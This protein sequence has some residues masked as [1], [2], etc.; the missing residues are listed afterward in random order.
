MTISAR[1]I[2][3]D[4]SGHDVLQGIEFNFKPG[5]CIAILGTNGTGKSTLL[6]CLDRILKPSQGDFVINGKNIHKIKAIDAA[7][8]IG[9]VAQYNNKPLMTVFDTILLGRK[10]HIRWAATEND[11]RIVNE[12]VE[13]MDLQDYVYRNM[14]ELSGG[15]AQKVFIARALVQKPSVLLLDE[16]TSSLD[17]KNQIDTVKLMRHIARTQNITVFATMHDMNL[18]LR[19]ADKFLLLKEGSVYVSGGSEVLNSKNIF[20]VYGLDA[21][22]GNINGQQVIVPV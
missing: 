10:P 8:E 19:F 13:Q 11:L 7:K 9:Y 6:K 17:I 3:F 15:E 18:S 5:E 20:A 1:S 14:N 12:I 16:P 2:H 21:V 22:V 4:Y